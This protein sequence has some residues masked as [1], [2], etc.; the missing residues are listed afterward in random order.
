M[1]VSHDQD[2]LINFKK[3]LIIQ[4]RRNNTN[5]F[6]VNFILSNYN[7]SIK[8]NEIFKKYSKDL[9]NSLKKLT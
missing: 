3:A 1:Y 2:D 4:K 7:I 8:I 9:I 6:I 5:G